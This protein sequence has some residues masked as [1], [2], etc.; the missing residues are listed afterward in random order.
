MTSRTRLWL[1]VAGAASWLSLA[2]AASPAT[3]QVPSGGDLQ[4][5]L[6]NAQPGDTIV[7]A[8]G[9]TYV[10]NFT[11]PNKGGSAFVTV[12]TSPEGLP[13]PGERI[14]PAHAPRLA[15][16][17]SPNAAPALQTAEA[18]HHWRIVLIEFLANAGGAGEI[19][20]L[21][22]STQSSLASVPHDLAVDRCYVHGDPA[23]GQKRGIAL[24]SASTTIT[25]SYISD[26][27]AACQDTQAIAGWNGPGPFSIANN[28]LEAAGENVM[29][30]GGDPAI[31][32]LVPSD[33]VFENNTVAKPLEWRSQRWQIKNLFELKNARRVTIQSNSF[34]NT[35]L[36]AQIGVAILFT[37]RNQD[38]K[39][40]WC[41]VEQVVFQ[42]NV[43]R[44]A[45][46]GVQILGFDD[47]H[48]NQQ[49]RAITIK[50]NTFD[51]I[52]GQKWGG[53][54]YF[55][56]LVRGPRDITIDHN[57]IIQDHAGG[58]LQA[59]GGPVLGFVFTNN[60][61][62]HG[63]YGIKGADSAPGNDTIRAYFPASKITANVIAEA[64]AARYPPGNLFPSLAQFKSQFMSFATATTA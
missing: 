59:D 15:K 1:A 57:T 34:E 56:Q 26:I 46:L 24:N 19:V 44:H 33:I 50:D 14:N 23:V 60:L 62:R 3:L 42:Q 53:S 61:I 10:G 52:D 4:A 48:P 32:N 55:L 31:P 18:A 29:F 30:G 16:L 11:L 8:Q 49:T 39:C 28:Y 12:Q 43:V 54:G 7:L 20:G 6:V 17:R 40:P 36:Q 63:M 38:G 2:R 47:Q 64:D 13:A 58:I 51:D 45:G 21:G 37:G 41:Q 5:A 25:G 35:W 9:A 27:K 22:S